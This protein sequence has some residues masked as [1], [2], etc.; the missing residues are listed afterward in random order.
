MPKPYWEVF[1]E[2][3]HPDGA[4]VAHHKEDRFWDEAEA[5]AF[6]R[7]LARTPAQR[8]AAPTASSRPRGVSDPVLG[9][10]PDAERFR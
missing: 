1:A 4:F 2:F 3:E 10:F 7:W 5:K 6:V 9:L 8:P